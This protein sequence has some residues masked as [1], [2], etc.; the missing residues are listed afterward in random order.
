MG[1]G[2]VKVL[3]QAR[4][5]TELWTCKSGIYAS[6][7]CSNSTGAEPL[8]SLCRALPWPH[9]GAFFASGFLPQPGAPGRAQ[10]P[11]LFSGRL[12]QLA[13]LARF[14]SRCSTP[15]EASE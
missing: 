15:G 12:L 8:S 7:L 14:R 3:Q 13:V 11:Y 2:S 1:L 4:R 9:N 10:W 5:D 6:M